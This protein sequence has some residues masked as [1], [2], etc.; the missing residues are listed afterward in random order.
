[1]ARV[2]DVPVRADVAITSVAWGTRLD[3]TCTYAPDHDR[4]GVPRAVTYGLFVRTKDG[5]TEQVGTWRSVEGKTMRLAA[6]TSAPHGQ[7][8]SVEI[9]TASGKTVLRLTI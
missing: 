9:R 5:R 6:A 8:A 2:G 4:Y 1:M 3:L 7:I